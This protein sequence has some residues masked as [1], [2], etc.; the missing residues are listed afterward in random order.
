MGEVVVKIVDLDYENTMF[1]LANNVPD[2]I[3]KLHYPQKYLKLVA[4]DGS[5]YDLEVAEVTM[6]EFYLMIK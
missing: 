3:A 6:D 4:A 1:N 5:V 2:D